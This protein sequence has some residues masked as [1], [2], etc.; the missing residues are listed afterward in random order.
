MRI[1]FEIPDELQP[2]LVEY[3][4][5][6][7]KTPN[8]AARRALFNALED[9]EDYLAAVKVI[10]LSEPTISSEEVHRKLGLD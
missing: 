1:E 7:G 5:Y 2:V 9:R 4:Q 8:E 10:E 6:L 3:A